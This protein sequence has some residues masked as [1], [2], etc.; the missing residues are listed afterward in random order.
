M[1]ETSSMTSGMGAIVAFLGAIVL[2]IVPWSFNI[3]SR[4]DLQGQQILD[5]KELIN[6]QFDSISQRLERIEKALNGAL[7]H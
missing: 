6:V 3:K 5:L 7:K 2:G 4:V 1:S